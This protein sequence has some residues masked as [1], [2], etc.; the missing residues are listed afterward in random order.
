MLRMIGYRRC[1]N[2]IAL[3]DRSIPVPIGYCQEGLESDL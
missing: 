3:E 2:Q 1:Q